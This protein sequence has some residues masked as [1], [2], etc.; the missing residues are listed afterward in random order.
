ME[1]PAPGRLPHQLDA[2]G[3]EHV[4]EWHGNASELKM[5]ARLGDC[6]EVREY[7]E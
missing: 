2:Q 6:K 1:L 4:I 5:S 3:P 7:L